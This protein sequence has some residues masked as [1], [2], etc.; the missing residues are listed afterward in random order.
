MQK[1]LRPNP[2]QALAALFGV[3]AVAMGAWVAHGAGSLPAS[4]LTVLNTAVQ[5]QFWHA[6]ALLH[7]AHWQPGRW[8]L[9][10]ATFLVAGVSCFSGSLYALVLSPWRPGL[11]TPFGGL[12]LMGGWLV[13]LLE[14]LVRHRR[15]AGPASVG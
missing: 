13:I 3:L 9:L 11:L 6:L 1:H 5:Y 15:P 12:L 4:R 8:R 14:A 7:V 2:V 10:A